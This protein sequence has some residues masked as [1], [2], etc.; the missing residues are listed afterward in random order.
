MYM[1][2]SHLVKWQLNST[3]TVWFC[4]TTFGC[5][6]S[7]SSIYILFFLR[8]WWWYTYSG[9]C[10]IGALFKM[11]VAEGFL[12]FR[13][14]YWC[15]NLFSRSSLNEFRASPKRSQNNLNLL[16]V[17]RAMNDVI[18]YVVCWFS[19]IERKW[20]ENNGMTKENNSNW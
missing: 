17:R 4:R 14:K 20:R 10:A 5:A 18:W 13:P 11:A 8:E 19:P 2:S 15:D 6:T 16:L 7:Q 9:Y 3:H 12:K 1:L